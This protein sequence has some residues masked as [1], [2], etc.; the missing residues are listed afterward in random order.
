MTG[1]YGLQLVNIPLF[2]CVRRTTTAWVLLAEYFILGRRQ[3]LPVVLAVALIVLGAVIA[4][5]QSLESD[6]LGLTYT[7][8]NNVLTAVSMSVTKRF[9]DGT[10]TQ[11]FGLVFYNALIA[12]PLC[13]V[14]ATLLGEWEYTAGYTHVGEPGFWLAMS[15]ASVMGLVMTYVALLCS[16]VNSPLVTR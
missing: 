4:G 2:L 12:L 16:T 7:M 3:A 15:V 11:G 14:G 5:W 10:R 8:A 1:W 9:S 6:W 13:L